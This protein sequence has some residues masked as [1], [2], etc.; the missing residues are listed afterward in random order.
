[1][2]SVSRE[3]LR[4]IAAKIAKKSP[5]RGFCGILDRFFELFGGFWI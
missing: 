1:M 3:P 2:T 5:E 4:K